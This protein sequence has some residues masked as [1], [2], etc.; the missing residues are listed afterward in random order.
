MPEQRDD[1]LSAACWI[2]SSTT[3]PLPLFRRTFRVE[4]PPSRA[5]VSLCGLGHFEL[6]INGR[7]AGD[8]VLEPGWTDYRKT[9]LVVTHDVTS[10]LQPGENV[11]G[12]MLGNGMFN[13]VGGRYCK[14]KASFG[15]PRFIALLRVEHVDGRVTLLGSDASWR[16]APGPITF[17][18]IYGGEDHDARRDPVGWDAPGFND[19]SWSGALVC[20]GPGGQL[21]ELPIVPIR[22]METRKPVAGR[23]VAAGV[24]VFDIGQNLSGRPVLRMRGRAGAAVTLLPGELIDASGRVSQKNIG[25]PTSFTYTAR[26]EDV[27]T[28]TPRFSYTGFRYLQAE[29][30]VDL[31]ESVSAEWTHASA[32]TI[33]SFACSSELLNRIHAIVLAAMRSNMQSVL[34]DCPHREKLG[35]LEQTHLMGPSLLCNFD[36]ASL[37][38][39]ISRD[40]RDAQRDDGM[41][42][43]I[44]PRF[45]GFKPPWD[46]FNDS[47]EWGSAIV[48]NPW[49]V[50]RFTG[51]RELVEENYDAMSRYIAYLGGRTQDGI[52]AYGLGDWY[53]VGEGRPGFSKRTTLGLTATAMFFDDLRVMQRCAALLG[54]DDDA[55]RYTALAEQVRRA[56]NARF[57]DLATRRYDTAS[58]TACGMP[59]ALGLV[60]E[61]HRG[62]VLQTLIDDIRAH[63]DHFTA[64]DIGLRYVLL[65]LSEAGRSDVIADVATRTDP[66]GYGAQVERGATALTEAWDG[67]PDSSQNHFMLG[68]IEEWFHERLAGIRVDFARGASTPLMVS[69]AL[70]PQVDWVEATRDTPL[71][72]VSVRWERGDRRLVLRVSLP[73]HAE[74]H[75]RDG[76]TRMLPAGDHELE[77]P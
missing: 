5:G 14:F 38:A 42:P 52:L 31:V 12:V 53:D 58:Q 18:C 71:G 24:R 73:S 8:D 60:D 61:P 28:W 19:S 62:H 76:T 27:E 67:D 20:D 48:Q 35:W 4:H 47:P 44:A 74:I 57:F 65:A 25:K 56:F 22:V 23:D 32:R 17:S 59:L 49:M 64:G 3:T 6:R 43:T 2:T 34:T 77:T 15:T 55:K 46:V 33:G 1:L 29:G 70:V 10:L 9:C 72:L 41:V 13:V 50:Y 40:M 30:D 37:Y 54:R 11:L 36:L 39:K 7:K 16:T 63:G 21:V 68:H 69:P 45:T 26:G 66:P 75:W 51:R